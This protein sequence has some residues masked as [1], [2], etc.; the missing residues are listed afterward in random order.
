M[1]TV[2]CIRHSFRATPSCCQNDNS[3]HSSEQGI[4]TFQPAGW[5]LHSDFHQGQLGGAG[6]WGHS[7]AIPIAPSITRQLED[8]FLTFRWN[9]HF[10]CFAVFGGMYVNCKS[11]FKQSLRIFPC[12]GITLWGISP[13]GRAFKPA[14]KSLCMDW[15]WG[16]Q[17]RGPFWK[18]D[19]WHFHFAQSKFHKNYLTSPY[20]VQ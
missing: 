12:S 16:A 9:Q 19:P 15:R 8:L 11:L 13:K 17:R 20:F 1:A 10:L 5:C 14:P 4:W 6:Q 18:W 3:S 2:S 7:E